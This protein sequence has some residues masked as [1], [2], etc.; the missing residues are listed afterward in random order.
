MNIQCTCVRKGNNLLVKLMYSALVG[1]HNKAFHPVWASPCISHKH[2]NVELGVLQVDAP[3]QAGLAEL[4]DLGAL[5]LEAS[6]ATAL[7]LWLPLASR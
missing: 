7:A 1:T 3:L 2:T 5:L 6:P 4:A